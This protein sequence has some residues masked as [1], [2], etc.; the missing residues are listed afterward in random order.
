MKKLRRILHCRYL[1]L[2][3]ACLCNP[4]SG[5][6]DGTS[7]DK[8][9]YSTNSVDRDACRSQLNRIYGA[10]QE[11]QRRTQKLP[12]WLSD[13]IP[14]YIHDPDFLVCPYVRETGNIKKWREQFNKIP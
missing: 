5:V 14:D 2:I 11:Y 13:L 3:A 10:I 9:N 7:S 4:A 6:E 1:V 12:V 8:P